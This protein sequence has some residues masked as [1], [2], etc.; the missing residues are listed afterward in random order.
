MEISVM[1]GFGKLSGSG[2][3]L[4]Y[5]IG[6]QIITW[7]ALQEGGAWISRQ[8]S[9]VFTAALKILNSLFVWHV[10]QQPR[11]SQ[12]VGFGKVDSGRKQVG[13]AASN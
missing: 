7:P 3:E 13:L 2:I 8:S 4:K 10:C 12:E 1:A 5:W 11:L 9:H 6:G